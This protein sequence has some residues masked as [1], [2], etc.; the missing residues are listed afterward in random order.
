MRNVLRSLNSEFS[1][2]AQSKKIPENAG[3]FNA[4]LSL[5]HLSFCEEAMNEIGESFAAL[6]RKESPR[7]YH[8]FVKLH[9]GDYMATKGVEL[10]ASLMMPMRRKAIASTPAYVNLK[11]Q[12]KTIF[13][14]ASF[15]PSIVTPTFDCF[16]PSLCIDADLK[17]PDLR[18][19]IERYLSQ[20][21][22]GAPKLHLV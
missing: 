19:Q 9:H 11:A 5:T 8:R 12:M 1:I 14:S 3:M 15:K 22:G 16:Q 6:W 21:D 18:A 20:K 13:T 2:E 17:G 4:H 7:D 10:E